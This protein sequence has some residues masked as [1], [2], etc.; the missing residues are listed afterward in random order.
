MG[1]MNDK[2]FLPPRAGGAGTGET[3]VGAGTIGAGF[4]ALT[5]AIP[6]GYTSAS[7]INYIS[8]KINN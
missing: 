4:N 6:R 2:I 1:P 5:Y 3:K 7:R 8:R